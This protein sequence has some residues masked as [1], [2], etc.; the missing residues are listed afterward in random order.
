M[1]TVPSLAPVSPWSARKGFIFSMA[2]LSLGV[3]VIATVLATGSNVAVEPETGTLAAG[4]AQV[5]NAGASG[6]KAVKFSTGTAAGCPA[7]PA[8]PDAN[9]TGWQHTGVTLTPYT[10]PSTIDVDGI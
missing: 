7:Y 9:C 2:A 1:T 8:F 6:G 10:G 4:A 5:T 3:V